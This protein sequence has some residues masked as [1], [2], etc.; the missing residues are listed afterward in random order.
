MLLSPKYANR[1]SRI[2]RRQG[3]HLKKHL[4]GPRQKTFFRAVD[5]L[6]PL[7]GEAQGLLNARNEY[8]RGRW[9]RAMAG[10][11]CRELGA[12]PPRF[13]PPWPVY[14]LTV[15][16]RRQIVYPGHDEE[17]GFKSPTVEQIRETYSQLLRRLDYIGMLEPALYVSAHRTHHVSRFI[18]YHV[19]ALV[20]SIERR[21]LD[22]I[23]KDIRANIGAL[24]PYATAADYEPV[25]RATL[26]YVL[27]YATKMPRHQYQL[28]KRPQTTSYQQYKRNI[29]GVN[30]VRLYGAMRDI[31][32]DQLVLSGGKGDRILK[33]MMRDLQ[34]WRREYSTVTPPPP[35]RLYRI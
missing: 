22:E 16:D 11:L 29:N 4:R 34:S 3:R 10:N 32:L 30:S 21:K 35:E 13:I 15:T 2:E 5:G 18:H 19:H 26:L 12:K 24:L 7:R 14:F 31:T 27:N 23:C 25:T 6:P 17:Q 8:A 28:W 9:F 20:W 1:Y 33:R